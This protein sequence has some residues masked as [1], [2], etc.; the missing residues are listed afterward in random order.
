LKLKTIVEFGSVLGVVGKP[1]MSWNYQSL[2]HNLKLKQIAKIG[3]GR[4]NQL[5]P[6]YF[7][8]QAQATLVYL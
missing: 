3:F 2:F 1:S 8:A 5:S 7:H 6:Q 4:K